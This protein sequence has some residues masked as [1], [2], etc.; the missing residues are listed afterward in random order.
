M[1]RVSGDVS[2]LKVKCSSVIIDR[3][4][5]RD[6]DEARAKRMSENLNVALFGVPV[7]SI[8]EDNNVAALDGQHRITARR[9][10]GRGDDEILVEAHRGLTKKQ[11]AELF[12]RLNGGR[13][14]VRSWDKWRAR[15]VAREPT[16]IEMTTIAASLGVKFYKA[17]STYTVC[18]VEKAERVHRKFHTLED[19]LRVVVEVGD[20]SSQWLSGDVL[21]A[22][23][24]FLCKYTKAANR[25]ILRV[26]LSKF[27]PAVFTGRI[28][29]KADAMGEHYERTSVLVIRD[30]YNAKVKG[31]NR[32]K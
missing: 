31:K 12:L 25:E 17:P 11:E 28:K 1:H 7:V 20:G 19:T 16:A 30:L 8:R 15:L 10:A 29:A 9:M 5:Q 18:A 2:F 6:L 32:L 4:Y 22:I 14:A 24:S 21:V 26:V 23:G 3:E 13:T 27:N